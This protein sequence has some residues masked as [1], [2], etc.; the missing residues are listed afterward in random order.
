MNPNYNEDEE[1]I[2]EDIEEFDISE[3]VDE[4]DDPVI[5]AEPKIRKKKEKTG[6]VYVEPAV[7][8]EHI[9]NYYEAATEEHF[10][11]INSTLATMIDDI[12]TKVGYRPN[13]INYSYK[14]EMIGD[15]KLKMFKALR[16]KLFRLHTHTKIVKEELSSGKTFYYY[17]DKKNRLKKKS[18]EDTDVFE[19]KPDGRYITFKNSA[20]AYYTHICFNAY[21]NR[22]K[23]ERQIDQ[24]KKEYQE[25]VWERQLS[26][27]GWKNVR[28]P[29]YM[30]ADESDTFD[31]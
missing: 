16:D 2:V 14:S 8:W 13:F 21:L 6:E 27:E 17:Y 5:E 10:P 1:D 3:I 12:A 26:S 24:T 30:D 25:D 31:E 18:H 4:I 9:K 20:F 7:M 22:I 28:R 11:S 29:R 15:A 19:T 23:K